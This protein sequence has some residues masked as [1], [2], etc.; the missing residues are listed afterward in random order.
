MLLCKIL[1]RYRATRKTAYDLSR[2]DN[3]LAATGSIEDVEAVKPRQWRELRE[4]WA[5]GGWI[6]PFGHRPKQDLR[7]Y[8]L[9]KRREFAE[10]SKSQCRGWSV[11]GIVRHY[12]ILLRI[13]RWA[14]IEGY[15]TREVFDNASIV[16]NT[17]ASLRGIAEPNK[18]VMPVSIEDMEAIRPLVTDLIWDVLQIQYHTGMRISEVANLN[19]GEIER[20]EDFWLFVPAE[21]KTAHRS[22]SKV[23]A[24]GPKAIAILQKYWRPGFLFGDERQRRRLVANVQQRLRRAGKT[25]SRP[26][27][28]HQ[29][30]HTRATEVKKINGLEAA[31]AVL[32]NTISAANI[33]AERNT[34]LAIEMAKESG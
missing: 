29:L 11:G 17:K 8:T 33:Y 23:V 27:H 28:C 6:R 20:H 7:F 26:W 3:L 22:K 1:E 24:I 31:A 4:S 18:K 2:V 15:C 19:T 9:E 14:V 32:G 25:T 21:H 16:E 13:L 34:Q 5:K 10:Q 30:R 12:G